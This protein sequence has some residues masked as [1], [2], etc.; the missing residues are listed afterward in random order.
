[1]TEVYA[2]ASRNELRR[3][4]GTVGA[5]V[6]APLAMIGCAWLAQRQDALVVL[7]AVLALLV[8]VI[9][10]VMCGAG[11]GACVAVFGFAFMLFV[12]SAMGDYVINDRGVRHD[13]VI[14]DVSTYW[15]KHGDGR[16]CT[17][18]TTDMAK[19]R[20][21]EVDDPDGCDG[22]LAE[23]QSVTLVIDPEGWLK[24]RLSRH[25]NGVAPYLA[26]TSVGLLAAMASAVLYGRHWR[27]G[28]RKTLSP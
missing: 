16:A 8:L 4:P 12:G 1:M 6:L 22:D 11:P 2:P 3:W 21:Y 17:A 10:W 9:A 28:L 15:R 26:W 20:A 7:G 27:R 24:P 13:A 14:G 25:V 23:G 19:P 18:V 5:L